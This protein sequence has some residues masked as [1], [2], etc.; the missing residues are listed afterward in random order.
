MNLKTR[1]DALRRQSGTATPA[2]LPEPLPSRLDALATRVDRLA[3][4]RRPP[5]HPEPAADLADTLKGRWIAEGVL[6]IRRRFAFGHVHGHTPLSGLRADVL[7]LP[8]GEHA[9]R[10]LAFIDTETSGLAGGT[11]TVAF[12][13]GTAQVTA[14]GLEVHQFL[15]T[16]FAAEHT[17]LQAVVDHLAAMDALVSYNGKSFDLTLLRDRHRLQ[18]LDAPYAALP[19]ID[20]LHP[21]RR[22]FKHHWPNCRLATVEQRLLGFERVNDLPGSQV[23]R[24][25]FEF[26]RQGRSRY[27]PGV[28]LHNAL[29]LVTLA[30]L[31]Q[32]PV[33]AQATDL[34]PPATR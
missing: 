17:M 22:R 21:T 14:H 1:L 32:H 31:A 8:T 10:G 15:M 2:G 20:L 34:P 18:G 25:W 3:R 27:L 29:D 4:A 11:G 24:V 30:A 23:P 28:L 33:W 16:R 13:I 26:V 9:T 19:H 6:H 5:Q 7:T 12:L